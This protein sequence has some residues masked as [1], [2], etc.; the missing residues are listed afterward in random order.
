MNPIKYTKNQSQINQSLNNQFKHKYNKQFWTLN[1]NWT[2]LF[3]VIFYRQLNLNISCYRL[4][5]NYKTCDKSYYLIN[6]CTIRNWI[7]SFDANQYSLID[8]KQKDRII[9]FFYSMIAQYVA[10]EENSSNLKFENKVTYFML[11]MLNY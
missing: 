8:Q 9:F 11:M 7:F 5:V 4:H 1:A 6:T 3:E 10:N 2:F